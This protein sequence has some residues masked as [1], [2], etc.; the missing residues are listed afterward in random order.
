MKNNNLYEYTEIR[1]NIWQIREDAGV[2][3][4][5]IKGRELAVLIDT[6]YGHRTLRA[7]VEKHISTPYMG[8]GCNKAF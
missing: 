7:F 6:G 3:C 8:M 4:T 1:N 2:Y 5:L